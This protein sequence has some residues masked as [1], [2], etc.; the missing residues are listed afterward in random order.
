MFNFIF[1]ILS[2]LLENLWNIFDKL[3]F[4]ITKIKPA[5]QIFLVLSVLL[6]WAVSVSV[7]MWTKIPYFSFELILMISII[8]LLSFF[9]NLFQFYWVK[10]K[11]L[12]AIE[13]L[14]ALWPLITSVI[15][16]FTFPSEREIKY[17]IAIFL[18]ILIL[19]I[20]NYNYQKSKRIKIKTWTLLILWSI[21]C[22][23]ILTNTYKF[24]LNTITPELLVIFR[25]AWIVILLPLF[26]VVKINK[27]S[28][29]KKSLKIGLIAWIF[30]FLW[31]LTKL[32]S[33]KIL[34]LNFTILLIFLWPVFI[35][36]FSFFILKEKV[37]TKNIISSFLILLIVVFT[38]LI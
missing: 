36:F 12:Q 13:P 16:F 21:I 26:W 28:F 14:K 27:K 20:F 10:K 29:S 18:A 2:I 25:T 1:P 23:W 37:E 31:H 3:N 38:I 34:G 6:I 33:I 24:V 11:D 8:I 19:I 15:A 9:Q 7:F 35:F 22:S 4:N 30:H 32:Y 17:I 5:N